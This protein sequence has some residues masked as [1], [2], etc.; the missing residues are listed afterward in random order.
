M[1]GLLL[2]YTL[3]VFPQ[4][5]GLEE[6][7]I[8]AVQNS[9]GLQTLEKET[10]RQEAMV[11]SFRDIPKA[12]LELQY[13]NIQNAFVGDYAINFLQSFENPGYYKAR[14]QLLESYVQQAKVQLDLKKLDVLKF[15]RENYMTYAYYI[16]LK[17]MYQKHLE[18]YQKAS[19]KADIRYTSGESSLL[20]KIHFETQLKALQNAI[21]LAETRAQAPY[22]ILKTLLATKDSLHI[23]TTDFMDSRPL[24]IYPTWRQLALYDALDAST[25][26][27]L[28]V[29]QNML[30]PGFS[31]GLTNQSINGSIRQ[32]VLG[33]GINIPLFT[34]SSRA[35]INALGLEKEVLQAKKNEIE[36]QLQL[37]W[38]RLFI[39][40]KAGQK[41][42]EYL[43]IFG[44]PQTERLLDITTKQYQEGEINYLDF[45]Q[46]YTQIFQIQES[47]LNQ[48]L[49]YK[50]QEI[51]LKYISGI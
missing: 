28:K 2:L 43:Q 26:N 50:L 1:L 10:Q 45:Q 9:K 49:T 32:F 7:E 13:G 37:E 36:Q 25:N 18:V 19:D 39:E 24:V 31:A 47:Y 29:E 40:M 20:E 8:F 17:E 11:Q 4:S 6:I 44:I 3:N 15:C 23:K 42:L 33:V 14:R 16:M 34:Q 5:I 41:N 35:R 27:A 51:N 22:S 21:L 48:L 30:K 46:I 12:N 38:E